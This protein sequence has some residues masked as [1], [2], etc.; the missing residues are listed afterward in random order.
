MAA[1]R[2]GDFEVIQEN[3]SDP[4]IDQYAAML[5]IIAKFDDVEMAVV[6]FQQM[7]LRAAA[8]LADQACGLNQHGWSKGSFYEPVCTGDRLPLG[9]CTPERRPYQPRMNY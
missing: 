4:F 8:H 1:W 5:R 7:R 3:R 2:R 6:A 9:C